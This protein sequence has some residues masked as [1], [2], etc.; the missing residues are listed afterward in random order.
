MANKEE[1]I[2]KIARA[3]AAATWDYEYQHE[4]PEEEWVE[5]YWSTYKIDAQA[6]LPFMESAWDEAIEFFEE[7]FHGDKTG[8]REHNPYA[9]GR[10]TSE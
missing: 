4:G 8:A 3:L 7:H 6:V 10:D 9:E 2:E 5:K 1:I